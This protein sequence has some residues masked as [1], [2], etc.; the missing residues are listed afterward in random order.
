M[1]CFSS[2]TTQQQQNLSSNTSSA[3]Y[4]NP[5]IT[6]LQNTEAQQIQQQYNL[7][8][9]PVYGNTQ[10]AQNLNN[11]NQLTN[12]SIN[13]LKSS[14]ARSGGLAGGGQAQGITNLLENK[15]NQAFNF[16]SSIPMLNYQAQMQGLQ[17]ANSAATG[18]Q[19]VS[20]RTSMQMGSSTGSGQ[21]T[22]NPSIMSDIGQVAGI[23]GQAASLGMGI[24]NAAS[25]GQPGQNYS[26]ATSPDMTD[27]SNQN[28]QSAIGSLYNTPGLGAAGGLSGYGQQSLNN[29]FSQMG[30]G[31]NSYGNY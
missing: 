10:I 20:P 2:T 16:T 29:Y 12:S 21:T 31:N 25:G 14:L 28:A 15:G 23:A 27:V 30:Y 1:G 5:N 26:F 4:S 11:L 19:G 3:G 6:N 7:A 24:A 13:S 18:L 22:S 9:T 8:N 17:A